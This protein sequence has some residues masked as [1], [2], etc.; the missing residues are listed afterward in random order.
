[1]H[2]INL[3]IKSLVDILRRDDGVG[4]KYYVLEL[5]WILFLKIFEE[6]ENEE[7]ILT[8]D[9]KP[10][11]LW[12]D[13][14]WSAWT[15]NQK[16]TENPAK[17]LDFVKKELF[18]YLS[19]LN[20]S[21][22]YVLRT[23][24]WELRETHI[25]NG[26]TLIDVIEKLDKITYLKNV[27][28]THILSKAYE[29]LLL[30]MGSEAGWSG[31]YYTPRAV[32]KMIVNIL[33]PK[34]KV[35]DPFAGSW[36]FLVESYKFNPR[37]EI[38]WIEK[39]L[40]AYLVGLMN[41]MLHWIKNPNYEL[42]NTFLKNETIFTQQYDFVLT[43]PPFGG[44]ESKS[45]YEQL[46]WADFK[47]ASTEALWLQ[48]VMKALKTSWQAGVV[49]PV[50]QI[51]FWTWNFEKIRRKL[52]NE[53]NLK[54][55]IFLPEGSFASVWTSIKTAILIFEKWSQT[56]KTQ[57]LKIKWKYTK[58]KVMKYEDVKEV[59]DFI[60]W[61]ISQKPENLLL[62]EINWEKIREFE[63]KLGEIV[64]KMED[65]KNQQIW[66]FQENDKILSDIRNFFDYFLKTEFY[67]K[68][69]YLEKQYYKQ[70]LDWLEK[71][72]E[73]KKLLDELKSEKNKINYS[74]MYDFEEEK[75]KLEPEIMAK[76]VDY[77]INEINKTWQEI[78]RFI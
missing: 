21:N 4:T 48:F 71:N 73:I 65:F 38:Y 67:E 72:F 1:M 42:G 11:L 54:Y 14:T 47:I 43:N 12:T 53:F 6:I 46:A 10:V 30:N 20:W 51:F 60:K 35:L 59:V 69:Q 37:C 78:K 58:K 8:L 74:F 45:V 17:M 24:F 49:L 13:Y 70:L 32:I 34:W 22:T 29:E 36:G 18:P 64:S 40:E 62:W 19:N 15:K 76:Q 56:K 27:E 63:A 41:L 28:D 68:K 33:Q 9:Y 26:T 23:I 31:E 75:Q 66:L 55:I 7:S 39:K 52:V 25:R 77:I 57:V 61:N 5:S 2:E 16:Y 44:K 3:N 50:G